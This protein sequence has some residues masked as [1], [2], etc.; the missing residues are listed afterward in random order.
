MKQSAFKDYFGE[1]F[2][3]LKVNTINTYQIEMAYFSQKWANLLSTVTFTFSFIL[4]IA[5]I[6]SNVHEIASYTKNDSL[7]LFI[8]AQTNYYVMWLWGTSN[9][10]SLITSVNKGSLDL[11]LVKP[12]PTLFY[13]TFQKIGLI[14]FLTQGVPTLVIM[15]FFVN[16]SDIYVSPLNLLFGIIVF[17]CGQ[18]ALNVFQFLFALPVFWQGEATELFGLSMEFITYPTQIPFEALSSGF[19]LLFTTLIPVSIST[20]LCTSV[21]LGKSDPVPLV[22][23]SIVV[24]IVGTLLKGYLW[25]VAMRQYTSASS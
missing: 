9:I 19:K 7:F 16:W 11:F 3:I 8:V 23:L 21:L 15:A 12:L 25:S 20:V 4:F 24:A 10:Q 17:I 2:E 5:I 18:I 1:R 22:L 6:Y 14:G 13:V